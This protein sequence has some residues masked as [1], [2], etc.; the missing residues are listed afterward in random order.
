LTLM[1]I[2]LCYN[3]RFWGPVN[4]LPRRPAGYYQSSHHRKDVS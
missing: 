3:Q 2:G 4:E 1:L